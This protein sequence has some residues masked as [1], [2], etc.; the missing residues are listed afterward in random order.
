MKRY[1]KNLSSRLRF[2]LSNGGFTLL[3]TLVAI[4]VLAISF[5]I[6]LQLFSG[7]LKSSKV[8]DEYTRGIFHAR[9]KVEEVLLSKKLSEGDL[10]G[11][12][13]D[14]FRWKTKIVKIG[15]EEKEAALLP[16]ENFSITV[17]VAWSEGHKEK[18]IQLTTMK[19]IEKT[20]V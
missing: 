11:E 18:Q 12:F 8:S 7:G 3:E 16:F 2:R 10:E 13:E 6:I 9:E 15:P 19:T 4:S 17:I 1:L 14:R 20:E 5:T